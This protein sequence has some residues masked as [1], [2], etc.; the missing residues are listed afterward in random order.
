M[1]N[2]AFGW[3]WITLG[4]A[5]GAVIGVY[6]HRDEWLGGYASFPRRMVR[7]GHIAF[8]GLGLLNLL[9]GLTADRVTLP[10]WQMETAAWA[11]V[12]GGVSMPT[13][14]GLSAWRK[15]LRHLFA[16][17]VAALL[18]GGITMCIGVLSS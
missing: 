1:L 18:T 3:I 6:F 4:L 13:V 16:I 15:P 10:P 14:C 2:I 12:I 5:S 8:L 9:F 11:F 17:P 7:L